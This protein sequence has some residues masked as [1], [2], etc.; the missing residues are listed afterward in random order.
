MAR[1]MTSGGAASGE[2]SADGSDLGQDMPPVAIVAGGPP[3]RIPDSGDDFVDRLLR[4][5]VAPTDD[6]VHD[7]IAEMLAGGIRREA[8]VDYFIPAVAERLGEGWLDDTT[9]FAEV[10][11]AGARLQGVLH[12]IAPRW[13]E[14]ERSSVDAPAIL[15]IVPEG[16]THTLGSTVL[17]GQLRRKGLSVHFILA[18]TREE[19]AQRMSKTT[20]NAV[21]VSVTCD[22]ILERSRVLIDT[23]RASSDLFVPVVIGGPT[24]STLKDVVRRT[25]ADLAT[26]SLVEGLDYCNLNAV[27]IDGLHPKEGL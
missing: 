3:P 8:I 24:L 15:L 19:L 22:E 20:F 10:T 4:A 14:A 1:R 7:A 9:S 2:R 23:V 11:I 5:V 13:D 16:E 27:D 17:V 25:G 21:F 18:P 12:R 26:N 6:F